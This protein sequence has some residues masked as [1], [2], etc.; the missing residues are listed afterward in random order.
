MDDQPQYEIGYQ[1]PPKHTQWKA[2][3]SGN[4][5]GR[6]K[7]IKDFEKL[8][9]IELSKELRITE[10]G[11]Q[12]TLTKREVIIKTLINDAVRSDMRAIKMLLSLM[13]KHQTIEGFQPDAGDRQA[14]EQLIRQLGSAEENQS[15]ERTDE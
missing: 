2:G 5:N 6:P 12:V 9:D 3:Q 8:I 14:F 4:P 15:K 1:K 10:G 13:S 7:K 11:R